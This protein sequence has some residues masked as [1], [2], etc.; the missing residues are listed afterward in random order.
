MKFSMKFSLI[1]FLALVSSVP[2]L[3]QYKS[4]AAFDPNRTERFAIFLN[5]DELDAREIEENQVEILRIHP[6][7]EAADGQLRGLVRVNAFTYFGNFLEVGGVLGAGI[8]PD[9]PLAAYGVSARLKLGRIF[10]DGR[11]L[12]LKGEFDAERGKLREIATSLGLELKKSGNVY[13]FVGPTRSIKKLDTDSSYG[14]R[15]YGFVLGLGTT[16]RIKHTFEERR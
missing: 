3:A 10:V 12:E 9:V 2:A 11:W 13:A 7:L 1:A 6:E 8:Y 4:Q 16:Y 14:K 5:E 15:I